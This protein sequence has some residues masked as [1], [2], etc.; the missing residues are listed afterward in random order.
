M[1]PTQKQFSLN[2]AASKKQIPISRRE[3]LGKMAVMAS[4]S[5]LLGTVPSKANEKPEN[6]TNSD[7]IK[8]LTG[9]HVIYAS[10]TGAKLDSNVH[11]GGGTD[12][13]AI[14]QSILD[15][16]KELDSLYLIMDGA[17]LIRGL[18]IHT[19][20]TIECLNPFCG[21]FLAPQ[22]NRAVIRNA[23]PSM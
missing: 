13:T 18:D 21:F 20:T 8:Y 7:D 11:T 2:R 15:K 9:H 10:Q 12:D 16:A 5:V 1:N 14:L 19:N 23:N 17:A 3:L 22:S 4:G 6:K